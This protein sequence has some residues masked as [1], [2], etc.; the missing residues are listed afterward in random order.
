MNRLVQV[1][2]IAALVPIAVASAAAAKPRA[3]LTPTISAA[4][5]VELQPAVARLGEEATITVAGV[6]A[7]AVEVRLAATDIVGRALPWRSLARVNGAWVGTLPAPTMLGVY[8]VFLRTS[9]GASLFSSQ[10]LFLRVFQPGTR[11]RPAF[12]NPLD[13]ARWWV[14]AVPHATLVAVKAWPLPAFDRRDASLHRL[15][16]VAYSPPGH[17][18]ASERLGMFITAFRDGYNAP[19][20]FLEATI[21]P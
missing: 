12:A 15:F 13:V 14:G 6:H 21:E 3:S 17:P 20:Q 18:E 16:V 10:R 9:A 11:A 4:P 7:R 8:P 19:W 2:A 1:V 5:R